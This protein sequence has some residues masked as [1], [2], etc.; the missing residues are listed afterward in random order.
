[1]K[2]DFLNFPLLFRQSHIL[3]IL[4]VK[5][6]SI[7]QIQIV[8]EFS[9]IRIFFQSNIFPMNNQRFVVDQISDDGIG[10]SVDDKIC[11]QRSNELNQVHLENQI[12]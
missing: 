3:S 9:R 6:L 12:A 2:E 5:L 4:H 7:F 11:S 1:M 10:W 8:P